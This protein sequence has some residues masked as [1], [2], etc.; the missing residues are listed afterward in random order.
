LVLSYE[1]NKGRVLTLPAGAEIVCAK[2]DHSPN[3][4][5]NRTV[6]VLW[7]GTFAVMFQ[8]DLIDK[9]EPVSLS[10]ASS[11]MAASR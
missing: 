7:K 11:A 8:A 1:G 6:L 4:A 9:G 10:A 5:P 2:L 3:A